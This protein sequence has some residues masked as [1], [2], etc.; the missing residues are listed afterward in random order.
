MFC[1]DYAEELMCAD[2]S[3]RPVYWPDVF[4]SCAKIPPW[5]GWLDFPLVGCKLRGKCI[6][7]WICGYQVGPL[8]I[9]SIGRPLIYHR[10]ADVLQF[11]A[12]SFRGVRHSM[13]FP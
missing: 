12:C 4:C 3:A 11:Y 1:R 13:G 2:D 9:G 8:G 10:G 6:S 7:I 5:R